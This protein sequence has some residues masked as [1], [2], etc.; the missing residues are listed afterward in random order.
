MIHKKGSKDIV[1]V[2]TFIFHTFLILLESWICDSLP[3]YKCTW[4]LYYQ[5]VL[6]KGIVF[7]RS[8]SSFDTLYLVPLACR[9]RRL[10]E[11]ILVWVPT[12]QVWC[13]TLKIIPCS[14][15]RVHSMDLNIKLWWHIKMSVSIL[16]G[17]SIEIQANKLIY[18]TIRDVINSDIKVTTTRIQE[19]WFWTSRGKKFSML[20]L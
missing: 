10:N 4:L 7:V 2:E 5:Y 8:L 19:N 14:K 13:G 6:N 15:I 17:I 12:N 18:I 3:P 20:H 16:S 9:R 11:V 1:W